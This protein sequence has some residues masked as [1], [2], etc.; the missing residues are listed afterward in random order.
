VIP[1]LEELLPPPGLSQND[2][3]AVV[4]SG[5]GAHGAYE[6]GVLKALMSGASWTTGNVPLDPHILTGTS[7]G[8]YNAAVL[9]SRLEGEGPAAAVRYLE[10]LWTNVI[11]RGR[12]GVPNQIYRFRG[13]P[14]ELLHPDAVVRHPALTAASFGRD[15]AFLAQDFLQRGMNL[16]LGSS[17]GLLQRFLGLV[18]RSTFI[19]RSPSESLFRNTIVL[20]NL[21]RSPRLLFLAA[22]D[23][24]TGQL[25]LFHNQDM[26]DETGLQAIFAS[27]AIPGVFPPVTIGNNIYVDG[28][29]SLNTPLG[30][31]FLGATPGADTAHVIYLDPKVADI[32]VQPLQSTIGTMDRLI[33]LIL[34]RS[35]DGDM[36]IA[37][38]V[39]RGLQLVARS[40]Q[41]PRPAV[42][43]ASK[44]GWPRAAALVETASVLIDGIGGRFPDSP[45]TIHRYRP[46]HYLGGTLSLL[47][48]S[49]NHMLDLVELGF[50]DAINHDCH[51]SDCVLP[52]G[53]LIEAIGR[54]QW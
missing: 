28:G 35:I 32:P 2:I 9:M 23:W 54:T 49:R 15:A 38:R 10:D 11:P 37:S 47:N 20:E 16:F 41:G 8:A 6:V 50:N 33:T 22:T 39:N 42:G 12:N 52:Q 46:S 26:T 24:T 44:Q 4:L 36:R 25:R 19:S 14:G 7:I 27:S 5:G 48:F 51:A 34:S 1:P 30:P 45:K 40:A 53:P 17:G 21:R 29:L 13:N 43:D 18:D 31:A 3:K